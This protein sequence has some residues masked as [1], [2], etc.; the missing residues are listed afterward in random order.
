MTCFLSWHTKYIRR[1]LYYLKSVLHLRKRMFHFRLS[2]CSTVI[3]GAP[4]T[5]VNCSFYFFR[6]L[7]IF[8]CYTF[9]AVHNSCKHLPTHYVG[10]RRQTEV[11]YLYQKLTYNHN[12][13]VPYLFNRPT[14]CVG[15]GP[16]G[17]CNTG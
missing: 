14:N 5:W 11:Y 7:F 6:F 12:S 17:E 1:F 15:Y 9:C 3:F 10:L 4:S 13:L 16:R 8:P 2:R